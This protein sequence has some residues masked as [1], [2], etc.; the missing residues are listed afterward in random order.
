MFS[1]LSATRVKSA[2]TESSVGRKGMADRRVNA[3]CRQ[4]KARLDKFS[5]ERTF[6]IERSWS[7]ASPFFNPSHN[8][9]Q[10]SQRL[11][12]QWMTLLLAD[13]VR[14]SDKTS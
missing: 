1:A 12:E 10:L 13:F 8:P 4:V 6:Y 7:S 2:S 9:R 5:F 11:L 3:L 14:R